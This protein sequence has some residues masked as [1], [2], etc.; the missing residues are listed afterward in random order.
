MILFNKEDYKNVQIL[1]HDDKHF[2]C[3]QCG[4]YCSIKNS[5]KISNTH[6][7]D[8]HKFNRKCHYLK[9]KNSTL[10]Q[11]KFYSKTL[12]GKKTRKNASKTWK[13]RNPNKLK[14]MQYKYAK[15]Y[16]KKYPE[17]IK[18]CRKKYR[19]KRLKIDPIF[20]LSCGLRHRLRSCLKSKKWTKTNSLKQYIGCSIEELKQYLEK[21]FQPGMTWG[22]WT[23]SGWHIDHIIP[24][25]SAKTMQQLLKLCHYTNLQPLWANDNW[26]KADKIT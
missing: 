12:K 20:K 21:Q 26:K 8:C 16:S 9:N 18:R 19:S 3:S 11:I 5:Y 23:H 22:N 7:N 24:L 15:K 6:C 1:K 10:K 25:S 17:R 14:E 4:D 2:L 13:E